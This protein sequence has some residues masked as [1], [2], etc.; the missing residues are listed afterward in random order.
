MSRHKCMT[1]IILNNEIVSAENPC[2]R[3]HDRGLLL[4]HGLF[5]TILVKK[6]TLPALDYHWQRLK[7][8][9]PMI[10]IT[11]PFTRQALES[12]L[13]ALIINNDLQ[14]KIAGARVTITYGESGRGILPL[15][16]PQP[17][18][19]ISV[20][21]CATP[22]DRPYS[23]YIVNTR[24]NEHS[25]SARLKS[26]SYL[27]NILAKQEA[28]SQGYDEAIL[29]NTASNIADGSMSNIYMVKNGKIFTP[30][31]V[32][33]ALPGVVRSILLTELNHLDPIIEKTILPTEF[34]EADEVFL[35]NALMGVQSVGKVDHKEFNAFGMANKIGDVLRE[36]K[37]YI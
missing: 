20:F 34:L 29:L 6:N 16:P 25:A 22:I 5:E 21:E 33:G 32:D 17:N 30:P 2:I 3:Y 12:M 13:T 27:D 18:F 8:S 24:K 35:T 23:A 31:V 14:D 1:T 26:I 36:I 37:N 10:G 11:L 9:A 28:M 7:T 4:G 19:L 15:K